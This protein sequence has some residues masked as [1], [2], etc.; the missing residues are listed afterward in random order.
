VCGWIDAAARVVIV[1]AQATPFDELADAVLPGS[2]S[3]ILPRLC[4]ER[5]PA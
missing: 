3:A 1:N 5:V 4:G 2:L